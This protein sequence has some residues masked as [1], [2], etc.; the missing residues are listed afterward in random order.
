MFIEGLFEI[1]GGACYWLKSSVDLA[2]STVDAD[3]AVQKLVVFVTIIA[4]VERYMPWI[5][6]TIVK[7]SLKPPK[8]SHFI[9]FLNM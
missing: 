2:I 4:V 3:F 1:V 8:Y 5:A 6:D 7:L 9:S